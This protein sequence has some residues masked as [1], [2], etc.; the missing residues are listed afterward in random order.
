MDVRK[1]VAEFLGTFLF[2]GIGLIA[3][4]GLGALGATDA[5]K[6]VV[7][8]LAFGLG[9]LAAI[10]AFGHISG[11]HFNPA[12]T[13][14]MVCDRRT[15]PIDGVGY[16]VAQILGATLSAIL[17]LVLFDQAAVKGTI[18]APGGGFDDMKALLLEGIMTAIFVLVILASTKHQPTVAA[19]AIPLTLVAIHLVAVPFTG[20]SVNPA[21]SIGPAIIG[22]DLAHLWVYIVGPSVGAV[23]AWAVWMPFREPAT[24]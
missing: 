21:R 20:S 2:I 16:I 3:I 10:F 17:V 5:P 11:G 18:T 14:G 19:L 7:V 4:Q 24:D 9:L 22:G 8:P 1:V 12:V 23:I 15:T 6:L 13:I